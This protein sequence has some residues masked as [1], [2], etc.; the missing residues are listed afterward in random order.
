MSD[1]LIGGA[2][3][4]GA[5]LAR[6]LLAE[7]RQVAVYDR[8]IR[9]SPI[10]QLLP[11][12]ELARLSL[13]AGDVTDPVHLIRTIRELGP[14]RI[15]HLAAVLT[16]TAQADPATAVRVISLGT[17]YVL[18]AMRVM[19]AERLVWASS[20]QVFGPLDRYRRRHGVERI[21]DNATPDPV[22]IYGACKAQAELLAAHYARTWHLDIT[23]LRPCGALGKGR[24]GGAS[25]GVIE[26]LIRA[27]RGETVLMREADRVFP[28]MHVADVV[29]GLLAALRAP[30]RGEGRT[31]NLGAIPTTAR[32]LTAMLRQMVPSAKIE[33]ESC[34]TEPVAVLDA[35]GIERDLGFSL[36][37]SLSEAVA[38]VLEDAGA[39]DPSR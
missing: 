39:A 5:Y 16:P 27:A 19:G 31:Y 17:S 24:R 11:P 12:A 33:L 10:V 21:L 29:R 6:E 26:S 38:D 30:A 3:F 22:T 36:Q 35:G 9:H 28:L 23:G 2:G 37:H 15:V 18:E 20:A 8:D 1:L 32:E 7:G 13:L 4:I 14:W 25:F 34:P